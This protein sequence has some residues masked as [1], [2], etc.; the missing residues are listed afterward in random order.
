MEKKE[1]KMRKRKG[2]INKKKGTRKKMTKKSRTEDEEEKKRKK[3]NK[4]RRRG[5]GRENEKEEQNEE[6]EGEVGQ[7][8]DEERNG[9][10]ILERKIKEMKNEVIRKWMSEPRVKSEAKQKMNR[11]RSREQDE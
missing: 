4:M 5:I 8:G 2:E 7:E 3:R 9:G 6:E 10:K 11:R 1:V